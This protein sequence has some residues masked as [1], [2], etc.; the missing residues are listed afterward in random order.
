MGGAAR[1]FNN[2]SGSGG[3]WG[4]DVVCCVC[5][6]VVPV[7]SRG[8]ACGYVSSLG[9][10]RLHHMCQRCRGEA[11]E[12]EVDMDCFLPGVVDWEPVCEEL[13]G[14]SSRPETASPPHA[15]AATAVAS[16]LGSA[17]SKQQETANVCVVR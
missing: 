9:A 13:P 17:A 6:Q 4:Q 3:P 5:E 11:L 16:V 10:A 8:W 1:L 2:A 7:A 12:Q 15:P 14:P